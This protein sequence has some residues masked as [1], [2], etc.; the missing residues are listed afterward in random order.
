MSSPCKNVS[1]RNRRH[2]MT[3]VEL[4]AAHWVEKNVM[5]SHNLILLSHHFVL[6][7]DLE[8]HDLS[9]LF[10]F[11]SCLSFLFLGNIRT[12]HSTLL[13]NHPRLGIA[14]LFHLHRPNSLHSNCLFHFLAI[15]LESNSSHHLRGDFFLFS[16]LF[17]FLCFEI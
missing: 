14:M 5:G 8:V 6:V 4:L 12:H 17:L 16:Y 7:L 10:L 15:H 9:F 3:K 2:S 13:A 11:L 1:Q